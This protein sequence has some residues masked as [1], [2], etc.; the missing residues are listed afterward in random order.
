[1]D[2]S[3]DDDSDVFDIVDESS[4]DTLVSLAFKK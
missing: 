3:S 4:F 1:M 2:D